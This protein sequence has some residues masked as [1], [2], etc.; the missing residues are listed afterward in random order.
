MTNQ[1]LQHEGPLQI[2]TPCPKTW[3]QLTGGDKQRFCSECSLHVHNATQ[4]TRREALELASNANERVCMRMQ[5]DP[6]GAPVYRD[7][8]PRLAGRVARW[9]LSTAAGLLAACHRGE[10]VGTPENPTLNSGTTQSSTI[11]GKVAPPERLGDVALPPVKPPE[12]LGEATA[13]QQPESLP[14]SSGGKLPDK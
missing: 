8:R 7:S 5:F 3:A 9:A 11:M 13:V 1:P 10:S 14:L 12:V 2:K 4:L 6:S